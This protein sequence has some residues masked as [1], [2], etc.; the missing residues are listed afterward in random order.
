MAKVLLRRTLNNNK[1]GE[2]MRTDNFEDFKK[3]TAKDLKAGTLLIGD[4]S[5]WQFYKQ[6]KYKIIK[7]MKKSIW[8]QSL[9]FADQQYT[10]TEK[11]RGFMKRYRLNQLA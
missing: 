4:D 1:K 11:R 6:S 5:H 7:V 8:V 3:L 9:T 2:V 10:H